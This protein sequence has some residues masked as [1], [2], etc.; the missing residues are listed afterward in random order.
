MNPL[1]FTRKQKVVL[2]AA[3]AAAAA[4]FVLLSSMTAGTASA[5]AGCRIYVASGDDIP[6]GHDLNDDSSRYPEKLLA[7]HLKSPG[8]CLFNQGKNGQTS[9][10]YITGGG[11]SSAYNMRPDLLTIQLGEQN[12]TDRQHHHELLRQGQGPRLLRRELVRGT[13]PRQLVALDDLKNNYTTILQQ[14]R[15]MAV[16]AA[17]TRGRGRELREPVPAGKRR[18]STRSPSCACR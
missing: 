14:T 2:A 13:D 6:N 7:D 1:T 15:I 8:W 10:S 18:Q 9:S 3:F 17:A 11:L 16:P 12:S 5:L 4:G